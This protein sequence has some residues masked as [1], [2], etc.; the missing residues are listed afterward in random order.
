MLFIKALRLQ[1][2]SKRRNTGMPEHLNAGT[3]ECRNA[4]TPEC[5]NTGILFSLLKDNF[6]NIS[7]P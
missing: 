3:P 6:K 2:C 7:N 5:R 1:A 4:G